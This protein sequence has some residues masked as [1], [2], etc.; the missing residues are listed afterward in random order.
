MALRAA[1]A[2]SVMVGFRAPRL[3]GLLPGVGTTIESVEAV[4]KHLEMTWDD[5]VVLHTHMRMTGSWHLYRPGERWR[6][7]SS[8]LRVLIETADWQAV[9]FNAPVVEVYRSAD[10]RRHPLAGTLGPDLCTAGADLEFCA[11]RMAAYPEPDRPVGEVLLDQRVACGVGNVYRAEVLFACRLSPFAPVGALDLD[12]CRDVI[13][14]AAAML[15]AN[16]DGPGRIADSRAP[17]GLAVYGRA[18]K[19]CIDCRTV[20]RMARLGD[21]RR[22]V[23]WCPTCQARLDRRGEHRSGRAWTAE[24]RRA[25]VSDPEHAPRVTPGEP[26][27]AP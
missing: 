5:G 13:G 3:T 10:P 8:Q 16:L 14:M 21:H 19:P 25:R 12:D 4:G 26:P 15:R 7:P 23:Y 24:Q 9:C 17:D 11:E 2:G 22:L 6:K 20:I 1:L 18:G 27:E